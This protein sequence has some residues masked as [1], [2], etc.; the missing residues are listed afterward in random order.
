MTS[1]GLLTNVKKAVRRM[2][3]KELESEL[4]RSQSTNQL[5]LKEK[6]NLDSK[7][8]S[9]VMRGNQLSKTLF[10]T[11]KEKNALRNRLQKMRLSTS[12]NEQAVS[13]SCILCV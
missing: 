1:D 13:F 8:R 11:V 6:D 5:L 9:E 10:D 12:F 7:L 3:R 4:Q 2:S